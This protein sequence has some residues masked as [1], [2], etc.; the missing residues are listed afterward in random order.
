MQGINGLILAINEAN[1]PLCDEQV[2]KLA[3]RTGFARMIATGDE[4]PE[5]ISKLMEFAKKHGAQDVIYLTEETQV[6]DVQCGL[7]E[8]FGGDFRSIT[9]LPEAFYRA[10]F[11]RIKEADAQAT[12]QPQVASQPQPQLQPQ[13]QPAPQKAPQQKAQ[14]A[15][16][17]DQKDVYLLIVPT[18]LP[19]IGTKQFI[20]K[21]LSSMPANSEFIVPVPSAGTSVNPRHQITNGTVSQA[22]WSLCQNRNGCK[23]HQDP[24]IAS[25]SWY[26]CVVPKDKGFNGALYYKLLNVQKAVNKKYVIVSSKAVCSAAATYGFKVVEVAGEF[27]NPG[28]N[29]KIFDVVTKLFDKYTGLLKDSESLEK[30]AKD[31]KL[32]QAPEK[33]EPAADDAA[34]LTIIQEIYAVSKGKRDPTKNTLDGDGALSSKAYKNFIAALGELIPARDKDLAKE[35]VKDTVIGEYALE[36]GKA[37]KNA[38]DKVKPQDKSQA[39]KT[40]THKQRQDDQEKKI[41]WNNE[42]VQYLIVSCAE[43]QGL[44]NFF[45]KGFYLV[46][47]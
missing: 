6:Y 26:S 46:A 31:K 27:P 32:G 11:A 28:N 37:L 35:W 39:D 36:A 30:Y 20:Q 22:I 7:D 3:E 5:K 44:K 29:Q 24:T 2:E 10:D 18:N 47:E 9:V 25:S 33:W 8:D 12:P 13:P 4:T 16:Q 43:F 1:T 23:Q 21:A 41:Q 19:L 14:P 15:A 17:A 45:D 34:I 40:Y 38:Y 42:Q